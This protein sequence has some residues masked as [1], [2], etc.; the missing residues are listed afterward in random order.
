MLV[1]VAGEVPLGFLLEV[2]L[3]GKRKIKQSENI[4]LWYTL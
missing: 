1:V 2:K 3:L 4:I